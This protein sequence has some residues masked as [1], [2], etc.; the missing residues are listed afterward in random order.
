M[1]KK[2]YIYAYYFFVCMHVRVYIYK[3]LLI[4]YKLKIERYTVLG[5][6]GCRMDTEQT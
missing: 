4:P 5:V 3:C 2:I 6:F 1:R